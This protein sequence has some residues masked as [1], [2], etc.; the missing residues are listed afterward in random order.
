MDNT[1]ENRKTVAVIMRSKNEQ[2]YASKTLEVLFRQTYTDFTLY[3]V[4]SGST[5]G[6]LEAVRQHNPH[7]ENV[8]EIAPKEYIPG[9]V[10]N[11]MIART[12]ESVI[13][14]LNADCVPLDEYWLERLVTPVLTGQ[15][16]GA[17][18]RQVARTDA[19]SIVQYDYERAFGNT[20]PK[21]KQDH[22]FSA[23]AC[24]FTRALW[25]RQPFPESG[26]GED[27]AWAVDCQRLGARF[28]LVLESAVEHSHNYTLKT[29]YKREYGHG[30]VYYQKLGLKP[31]LL[32]QG[33]ASA[34][35]VVRDIL[36]ALRRKQLTDIPYNMLYR[37]TFNWAHY[38]GQC[39]GAKRQG[40]PDEFFRG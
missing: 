8:F 17:S 32:R 13:V 14:L 2:P 37:I 9:R 40:F 18:S 38:R 20:N 12:V 23:A 33:L 25:E 15:A 26:W 4:D 24:A 27:F 31:S 29:L 5:D 10:L 6:T 11:T 19:Y 36:F 1:T 35:H 39:T 3:N 16:D 7:P 21:K 34:K 22:F 28:E 30:I